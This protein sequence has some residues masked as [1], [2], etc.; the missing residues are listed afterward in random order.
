MDDS[1]AA[2]AAAAPVRTLWYSRLA[3]M[4]MYWS[5]FAKL[6]ILIYEKI[7]SARNGPGR[8]KRGCAIKVK[9]SPEPADD[10]DGLPAADSG[11]GLSEDTKKEEAAAS[12]EV[13]MAC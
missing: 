1:T 6:T 4:L 8:G 12:A 5:D 3:R 10:D 2:A 7:V 13:C 11:G 9:G